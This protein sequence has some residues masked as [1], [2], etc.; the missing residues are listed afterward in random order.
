MQCASSEPGFQEACAFLLSSSQSSPSELAQLSC[1]R[2]RELEQNQ[3]SPVAHTEA[4]DLEEDSAKISEATQ[5]NFNW[6][7]TY[8]WPQSSLVQVSKTSQLI[9]RHG[10]KNKCLL[11]LSL[12]CKTVAKG[13]MTMGPIFLFLYRSSD[14]EL[15]S[16]HYSRYPVKTLD[17]VKFSNL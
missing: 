4:Q 6:P 14:L 7:Q 2:I 3:I 12:L 13:N 11:W 1:R 15:Y 5:P 9:C 16:R 8:E 10:N 17:S